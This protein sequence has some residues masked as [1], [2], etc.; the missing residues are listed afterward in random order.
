MEQDTQ[1]MIQQSKKLGKPRMQ[2]VY[3]LNFKN[4]SFLTATHRKSI[5]FTLF[6]I[7]IYQDNF[8]ERLK[9]C[10][11]INVS[12]Y[13]YLAFSIMK[14]AIAASILEK[15]K[16]YASDGWKEPLLE[17]I[18]ADELPAFLGGNKTDPDGDPLCKTFIQHGQKI[19]KSYYFCNTEKKLSTAADAEKITVTR[20]SKEEISFEVTEADSYLEWEFETKDRDIGFF[21]NFRRNDFEEPVALVPKQR[22]DTCYEPEK[23]LFKCD[24]I[25]IYTLVFDNSYSWIYPKEI[26]YRA[27]L[28]SLVGNKI[29]DVNRNYFETS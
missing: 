15:F 17:L 3:I 24:E 13:F 20:L 1:M 6:C 16:I 9:C 22:I 4:L 7:K 25:G 14:T 21:L 8:P 19:P 10:F 27:R 18:D 26:Y 23:G 12:T 29:S 2:S 28:R 11:I 5:E